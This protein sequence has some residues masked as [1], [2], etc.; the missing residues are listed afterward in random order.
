MPELTVSMPAF[1]SQ[2]YIRQA[3]E[4]VL[5][6]EGIDF[7]LLIVDDGSQDDTY[8]IAQGYPDRRIHLLKN[9]RNRGIAACH[10]HVIQIS[11]APF[12]VHVDSDDLVLPGAFQRMM[13]AL[14]NHP[15]RHCA[16]CNFVFIDD[17]GIILDNRQLHRMNCYLRQRKGDAD[18]K[19][20]LLLRGGIAINH[21]RLY[22]TSLF[23]AV[24]LFNERLRY[25][26]DYDMG[27]RIADRFKIL[28]IPEF[29]Y[30]KRVHQASTTEFRV[31]QGLR[32]FFNRV[33]ICRELTRSGKIGFTR[34]RNYRM[35]RTLVRGLLREAGER[36]GL[37]SER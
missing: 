35:G 10:N 25:G 21:L 13:D 37:W 18:Y 3:I 8:A 32:F 9:S 31:L 26:E 15:E 2:K 14:R 16:H 12:L 22:R 33:R 27:L 5:R 28:L 24:G 36:L 4:S 17:N 34:E 6:Q 19:Q 20:E 29:L 11:R 1:N 23:E 7:E 30:C